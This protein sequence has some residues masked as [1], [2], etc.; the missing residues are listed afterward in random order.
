M[1]SQQSRRFNSYVSTTTHQLT[2][3][4]RF[5]LDQ[6]SFL[7]IGGVAI[8]LEREACLQ[9]VL[10]GQTSTV[11][12]LAAAPV[13]ACGSGFVSQHHHTGMLTISSGGTQ[14]VCVSKS[15]ACV[16]ELSNKNH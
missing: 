2:C 16:G 8:F 9:A 1:E 5:L 12:W 11:Q 7:E 14:P 3:A 10:R 6:A 15:L 13:C 4:E